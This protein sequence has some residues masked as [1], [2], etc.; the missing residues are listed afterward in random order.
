MLAGCGAQ[1]E[2]PP[3]APEEKPQAAT[4]AAA[5]SPAPAAAPTAPEPARRCGWLH[6]PTPG[7]WWLTDRDGEWILATQGGRAA[8]GMADMPDMSAHDW[9]KT[10]GHY[11]F[12]CACLTV[13]AEPETR[14]VLRIADPQPR[15]LA[16][17]R[18]DPAL[19][20]PEETEAS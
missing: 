20:P 1:G 4:A 10:N 16:Q 14:T 11:G 2:Q 18:A 8:E 15:P 6:N 19:P 7:N 3:P 17:C 5:P 9:Q 12:G 13:A